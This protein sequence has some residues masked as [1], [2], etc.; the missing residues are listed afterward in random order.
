MT[1]EPEPAVCSTRFDFYG[2]RTSFFTLQEPHTRL[3]VHLESEVRVRKPLVFRPELTHRWEI[4]RTMIRTDLSP[5]GLE[6]MEFVFPSS[7]V[8]VI[9]EA[10]EYARASFPTGRP[11]LAALLDLNQRIHKDFKYKPLATTI[12]TPV[13]EVMRLRQGVCQDFAHLMLS[14][15]RSMGLAA[16][17]VSGYLLTR[18]PAN[19][20]RLIGADASH[21]WVSAYIP[22][23][24]WTD[25]DPTNNTIPSDEHITLAWGRDYAD[26]SPL[27]GVILGGGTQTLSVAVDVSPV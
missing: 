11:I 21:A 8:P 17:Y 10:E 7:F 2:N 13:T 14:C 15:I 26:V 24:G 5:A 9:V 18:R 22:G 3:K 25:F 4:A 19:S 27:R 12:S 20:P 1:V 16:R 6:A 23:H